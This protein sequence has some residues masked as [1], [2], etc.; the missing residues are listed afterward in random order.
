MIK[1]REN[2]SLKS[3]GSYKIG[4][5]ARY[6]FEAKNISDLQEAIRQANS[7]KIKFFVLGAGTNVLFDD[8]GF[9]GLIL[10]PSFAFLEAKKEKIYAGSGAMMSEL[11]D[12]AAEKGLNG[13]EWAGGL[14]G[15]FGGAVFGNAGAFGGEIKD[16]VGTVQSLNVKTLRLRERAKKNCAFGYR[17]SIF[18]INGDEIILG[19]T[20]TLRGGDPE[21]IRAAA[22]EKKA[23]RAEKHPLE[24]HNIGSIFKNI[25]SDNLP[26]NRRD[27][28]AHRIKTDPFPVLPAA[29][30]LDEAG[31]RGVSCGGAMFSPKHPNFIVNALN[32][33]SADVQNLIALAKDEAKNKLE[34]ELEEE[35]RRLNF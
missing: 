3:L 12:F 33:T 26:E 16:S 27:Q 18:K 7:A 8:R 35:I 2:V 20:L 19:A 21:K 15:T 25:P 22:D 1:F 29:H 32:A 28:F 5:G 10:K 23:Y 17:T 30:V 31:L 9:D 34:I 4:G 14:P 24:Y 13:L 6:F 11:V